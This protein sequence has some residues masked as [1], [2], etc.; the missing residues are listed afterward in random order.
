MD[1]KEIN[2]IFELAKQDPTLF[3]TI[4]I[5]NLLESIEHEK[6]DFLEN[7]TMKDIANIMMEKIVEIITDKDETENFY[8]KLFGYRLVDEIFELHKV[9][10]VRW[11]RL[12]NGQ[13]NNN[14]RLPNGQCNNNIRLTNGG[15]VVD[16]KFLDT[17]VQ[18]LC[19]NSRKQFIQYKF[20]EC[21]TFQK[22]STEEQLILMAYEHVNS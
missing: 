12:P 19:L 21:I 10:H 8:K 16:I 4:D 5:E 9:K 15:I 13:C 6:N 1:Q 20:D 3:S 7:K 17:G 2:E 14:I 18:V 22:L 11:I